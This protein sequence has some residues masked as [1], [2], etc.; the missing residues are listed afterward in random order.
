MEGSS[1]G[2]GVLPRGLYRWGGLCRARPPRNNRFS[3]ISRNQSIFLCVLAVQGYN[4]LISC[5]GT[6]QLR[7]APVSRISVNIYISYNPF[8]QCWESG[9]IRT[10]LL[11]PLQPVNN[12]DSISETAAP[13]NPLYRDSVTLYFNHIF[14]FCITLSV[15]LRTEFIWYIKKTEVVL[16]LSFSFSFTFSPF[17]SSPF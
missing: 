8:T 16:C 15:Y 2:Y 5:V 1:A 17:L 9:Q 3:A 7:I 4:Q 13:G 6:D 12:H 14:I 10:Y 11:I